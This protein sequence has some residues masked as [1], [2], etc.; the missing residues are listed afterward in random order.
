MSKDDPLKNWQLEQGGEP[1]GQ[2]KLQDDEQQIDKH[3]QLQPSV[4]T[5]S[6]WQ[7]VA[8]QRPATR[9]GRN[10]VLP[11]IVIVAL[12]VALGYV[13]FVS[14]NRFGLDNLQIG[15]ISLGP[16]AETPAVEPT[17]AMEGAAPATVATATPTVEPTATSVPPTPS[18]EPTPTPALITLRV[19][20]VN[21]AAGVNA[22]R[23]PSTEAEIIRL[24]NNGERTTWVGAEGDWL[25]VILDDNQVAWVSSALMTIGVGDQI[26]LDEWNARRATLGLGPVSSEGADAAAPA[27]AVTATER[28]TVPVT[29]SAD[30]GGSVRLEPA[31]EA[32][33]VSQALLNTTMAA[34]GRTAAGDWLLVT[35]AD[36]MQGW[37]LTGL[38]TAG[39]D[40]TSLPVQPALVLVTGTSPAETGAEPTPAA[41]LAGLGYDL[42]IGPA[43]P[44]APYTNTLPLAGPAIA[45]SDTLG[46]N[47]RTTPSREGAVI[48]IVP[49][50]AVLPVVGRSAD[51]EWVQVTL[52]DSQRAWMFRSAVNASSNVD[53]APVVG[54]EMPAV[55][56]TPAATDGAASAMI[57]TLLGS[58]VRPQ[59][60]DGAEPL[61][62]LAMGSV[63]PV[64]ARSADNLWL[65]VQLADG[66]VGW[67]LA[68]TADLSVDIAAL[69]VAP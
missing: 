22:R 20:S 8:Y 3:M 32:Q 36:G 34:T 66:Q 67:I 69:P 2:W 41:P 42:A 4:Q 60:L 59:P 28:V 46:I 48:G 30:P 40:L 5:P 57:N 38:V 29:V 25:Q 27:P 64:T 65:Q 45:I 43:V 62:T 21:E 58:N 12:L 35:L 61:E 53:S 50:G 52:P 37:I 51:N 14:F 13:G 23:S 68:A 26:T 33:L 18:P 6:V 63:L 54:E 47:A 44:A 55:A 7:P 9:S 16:A 24:L 15:P 10:W 56:T 31:P 11:S 1:L 49:N 39:S 17:A 19:A